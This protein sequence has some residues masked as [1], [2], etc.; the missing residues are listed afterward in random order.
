MKMKKLLIALILAA[1]IQ[2]VKS[3]QDYQFT[4]YMFDNLSFNPGYAGLNNSICGTILFREQWSGFDGNPTTGLLNV[5][6]PV[7]MLRG[8]VGLTYLNDQLGFETNN[9]AR[10]SYS[11]HKGIGIGILGIGISAGIVQKSLKP[12]WITPSGLSWEQDD[13]I[14][15]T[16]ADSPNASGVAPDFNLGLFYKTNQIYVG[17]S[18]THL[19][20]LEMTDLN[21]KNV[22][23]YWITAGYNYDITTDFKLRPSLLVKSDAASTILDVNVNVLYRNMLWAGATYRLGDAVAPML[24]YQFA[25][26]NGATLKIGYAYGV[27]TSLLRSYNNGSHDIMLNYCFNLE[28][29]PILQ[30]S[31]NPRF[32]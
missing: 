29:P 10:L 24:G 15:R 6:A 4:H 20:G 27:T 22:H 1:G 8:G 26:D 14:P 11:Y 2:N 9:I 3:Q 12:D 21:I 13:A 5:H 7:Q 25:F 19:G 18:T 30:K 23:H 16:S 31:K 17:L 32:L 28:K